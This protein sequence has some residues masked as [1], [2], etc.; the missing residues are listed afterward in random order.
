MIRKNIGKLRNNCKQLAFIVLGFVVC[1]SLLEAKGF[2]V[3]AKRLEVSQ[4]QQHILSLME[5]LEKGWSVVAEPVVNFRP[6]ALDFLTQHGWSD[7]PSDAPLDTTKSDTHPEENAPT[8]TPETTG[9]TQGTLQDPPTEES[10]SQPPNTPS[11]HIP[12]SSGTIPDQAVPPTATDVHGVNVTDSNTPYNPLAP[13]NVTDTSGKP[14]PVQ[15]DANGQLV[16]LPALKPSQQRHI[17]LA[18]DSMMAVGLAPQLLREIQ[19]YKTNATTAKAYRAAT[20]L[21]RPDVFDWQKEYPL[22][23]GGMTPDVIIVAIG[24]NDTQNLEVNRKVLTIGSDEWR[25]VYEERLTNYLNMLTQDGATVLWLKL[26]PMRPSKYNRNV[27]I[28]NE[29]AQKVVAQN[30][31]VIWWDTSDRFVNSNGKFAEFAAIPP[32]TKQVRI[33]QSD[34]IHLTDSGAQLISADIIAW[35]NLAE[36]LLETSQEPPIIQPPVLEENIPAHP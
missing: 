4:S 29:V 11:T 21:A 12:A 28:V 10:A 22:M 16:P 24:A 18:G 33:R 19:P 27:T 31:R 7:M 14:L 25:A 13:A 2:V 36:P 8:Q 20:G 26:P 1:I 30:P 34:G 6:E 9:T 23:I 17:V 3:W 32:S 15:P 35:L 5:T